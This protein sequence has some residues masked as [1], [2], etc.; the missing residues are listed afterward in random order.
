MY[1]KEMKTLTQ[2]NVCIPPPHM[3]IEALFTIAKT[4]KQLTLDG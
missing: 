4:W 1:P 3:F 2:K